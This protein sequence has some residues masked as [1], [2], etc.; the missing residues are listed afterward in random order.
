MALAD[1]PPAFSCPVEPD[2]D[3][4]V[5]RPCGELDLTTADVVDG[6]LRELCDAGFERLL[7][8]LRGVSFMDSTGLALL[9]RWARTAEAD[10]I[11][12]QLYPGGPGVMRVIEL[13]DVGDA[14]PLVARRRFDRY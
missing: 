7:V 13:A 4:V 9:L 12:L 8:D 14:L 11:V 6:Q 5:L 2:R 1:L 3:R 10:G